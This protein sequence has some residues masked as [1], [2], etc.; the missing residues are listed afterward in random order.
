VASATPQQ[1]VVHGAFPRLDSSQEQVDLLALALP[2]L[3]PTAEVLAVV[4]E[5]IVT[6][7]TQ[8]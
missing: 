3:T 8:S 4:S 2:D 1:H 6:T 7:L 5:N